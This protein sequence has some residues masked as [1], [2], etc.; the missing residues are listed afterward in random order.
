MG[1]HSATLEVFQAVADP[2]RRGLL[3]QLRA[4]ERTVSELAKPF[5]VTLSAISQHLRIL[6]DCGLV[7]ERRVGRD[8]VYRLQAAPL[9]E[10]EDWVGHYRQFWQGRLDA[11]GEH[12]RRAP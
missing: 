6:R 10:V 11:L 12:L 5:D 1:R 3:D 8:H 9:R 7:A 2:T 4:G